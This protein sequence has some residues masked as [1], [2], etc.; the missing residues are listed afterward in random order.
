MPCLEDSQDLNS[1]TVATVTLCRVPR[2]NRYNNLHTDC[3][4]RNLPW[5]EEMSNTQDPEEVVIYGTDVQSTSQ[6]NSLAVTRVMSPNNVFSQGAMSEI[7]YSCSRCRYD[8]T[9]MPAI[10]ANCGSFGHAQC[11]GIQEFQSYPFCSSCLHPAPSSLF[12][13]P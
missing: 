5:R 12:S 9:G 1:S 8:V 11:S 3:P 2:E 6:P 7:L 10:C 4:L 13:Y